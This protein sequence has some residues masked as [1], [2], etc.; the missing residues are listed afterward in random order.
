MSTVEDHPVVAGAKSRGL[1]MPSPDSGRSVADERLHRKQRLAGA[2]RIFGHF[3]FSEGV[4]GHITVRDPEFPDQFWVNPFGVSF[5]RM[6]VSDLL[7]VDHDGTIVEGDR[8]VNAA[9]FAIHSEIHKARPDVVAAAHA[10]SVHAKALSSLGQL[11]DPLT[12]DA[13]AFYGDHTLHADFGGVVVDPEVG[14]QLA[15]TLGPHKAVIH[16]NHGHITVGHSVDEAAWWFI[17]F[18]RSA[19]AQLLA[20]AAGTPLPISHEAATVTRD[21]IGGH[22]AG[23]FQFQPMWDDLLAAGTDFL[24]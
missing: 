7:L 14:A 20:Q 17:T 6:R 2:L 5:N 24:D 15:E 10:H 9:A 11:L 21:Q 22:A 13:C 12:Q 3:G 23:W 4:A 8:P 18:E 1:S 19:Q 16:Q